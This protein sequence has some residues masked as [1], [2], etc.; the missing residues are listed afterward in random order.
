MLDRDRAV[1][2]R[3]AV[4]RWQ[5]RVDRRA[6]RL[7]AELAIQALIQAGNARP[8]PRHWTACAWSPGLLFVYS[9]RFPGVCALVRGG[10]VVTVLTRE[11]CRARAAAERVAAEAPVGIRRP[12]AA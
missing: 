5:R 6:T 2:T 7:Q 1:I 8:T 4:E 9:A 12:E 3:R 10:A 11:L